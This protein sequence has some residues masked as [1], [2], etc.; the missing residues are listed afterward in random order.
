LPLRFSKEQ[1]AEIRSSSLTGVALAKV[2]DCTPSMISYIRRGVCY[3][4][5]PSKPREKTPF[6]VLFWRH[7]DKSGECW[8]W[9]GA[10]DAGGY[11]LFGGPNGA[12][13][14]HVFGYKLQNGSLPPGQ[15]VRHGCD[16]PPCVRGEHLL[17]GTYQD[18]ADD[19]T[20]RGRSQSKLTAEQAKAVAADLRPFKAIAADFGITEAEI[21]HIKHGRVWKH[22][23]KEVSFGSKRC[24][25]S[26][27]EVAQIRADARP[28][29]VIA[30]EH[31]IGKNAVWYIKRGVTH[32]E[33]LS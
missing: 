9:T 2:F 21:G 13:G 27:Q 5:R 32:K 18:N 10:K 33:V 20:R 6:E 14:A 30:T 7:V 23:V 12:E 17:A 19:C 25:L 3:T 4:G 11:G 1:V 16:N 28:V 15:L 8:L 22:A 29:K 31:S 26:E 24:R